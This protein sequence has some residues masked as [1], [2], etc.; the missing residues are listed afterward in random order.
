MSP[1]VVHG[2][3]DAGPVPRVDASTNANPLGPA[4]VARQAV[5][6]VDLGPYPDPDYLDVRATLAAAAGVSNAEVAA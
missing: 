2:G 4:P 6:A 1:R 3:R 5:A